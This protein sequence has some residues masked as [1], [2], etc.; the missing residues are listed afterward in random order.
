MLP[1]IRLFESEKIEAVEQDWFYTLTAPDRAESFI[2]VFN[3]DGELIGGTLK[4]D[5]QFSLKSLLRFLT[6]LNERR[7]NMVP[8]CKKLVIGDNICATLDFRRNYLH[9]FR[10]D[11]EYRKEFPIL[12]PF[13]ENDIAE[14]R[15]KNKE[16]LS[17]ICDRV[18]R[19]VDKNLV[20]NLCL[21]LECNTFL[22]SFD[23]FI[24]GIIVS[25]NKFEAETILFTYESLVRGK[26]LFP[27]ELQTN[28]GG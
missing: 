10:C 26:G 27:L 20:E 5:H 4:P 15:V 11:L 17:K 7:H 6:L 16:K 13:C 8:C 2:F 19:S 9:L 22:Q 28:Q 25:Y 12:L 18:R 21:S 24:N 1:L 14:L 3:K 23:V